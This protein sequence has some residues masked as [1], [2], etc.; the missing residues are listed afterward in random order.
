MALGVFKLNTMSWLCVNS[1]FSKH[2]IR[3]I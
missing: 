2:N 1:L 3:C